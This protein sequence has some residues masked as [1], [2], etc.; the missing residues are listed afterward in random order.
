MV[1]RSSDGRIMLPCGSATVFFALSEMFLSV[2][3]GKQGP[4][5]EDNSRA[6][7]IDSCSPSGLL[8]MEFCT[9][10]ITIIGAT[11]LISSTKRVFFAFSMTKTARCTSSCVLATMCVATGTS[12]STAKRH[13]FRLVCN[14]CVLSQTDSTVAHFDQLQTASNFNNCTIS[15]KTLQQYQHSTFYSK[16]S[17]VLVDQFPTCS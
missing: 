8:E 14:N 11:F 2:L 17:C 4:L 6:F 9:V 12:F 3:K 13:H 15:P 10:V 5:V 1:K 7:P 16:L